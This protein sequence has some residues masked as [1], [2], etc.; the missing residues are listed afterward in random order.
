MTFIA[1]AVCP[2]GQAGSI[3]SN[4]LASIGLRASRTLEPSNTVSLLS[5]GAIQTDRPRLTRADLPHSIFSVGDIRID[6]RSEIAAHFALSPVQAD[7]MHDLDLFTAAW[8]KWGFRALDHLVGGFAVAMWDEGQRTLIL[9]RDHVGERPIYFIHHGDLLAFASLPTAL[10]VV[11]GVDTSL[12]ETYMMEHLA[13]LTGARSASFFRNIRRLPPGHF[14]VFKNGELKLCRYWHPL[15][16]PPTRLSRDEEYAEALVEIF[17]R[18][19]QA[20]LRT[21][22]GVGSHLS[23]GMDSGAVTATAALHLG[24]QQLTAFTAVPQQRFGNEAPFGRFG[25]EGP[26]AARLAAMYPNIQ[27]KLIDAS[28]GDMLVEVESMGKRLGEPVYNPLNLM[29][30]KAITSEA[31]LLGLTVL[32]SGSCGNVTLSNGGLIGLSESLRKGNW[33]QLMKLVYQLRNRGYT[34]YRLAASFVLTPIAPAWL[35]R[36]LNAD[37]KNF[38]MDFSPLRRELISRHDLHARTNAEMFSNLQSVDAYRARTFEYYDAG[39]HNAVSSLYSQV[40]LRDPTQDKRMFEFCFS[41]PVEQYLAGGQTRSLVRRAMRGRLPEATLQCRD[42]G[43]QSADWFLVM[44]ARLQQMKA[45]L[46]LIRTSPM[47][48]RLLDLDRLG[49]LLENWPTQGFE[50][51]EIADSW[52]YALSRGIAAGQFIRQFE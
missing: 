52:H 23:G 37:M 20:R 9:I 39:T 21:T 22:G 27:H 15:D 48:N 25:D 41:I 14:L 34:G 16:A 42:R 33:L 6:N 24:T 8:E 35:R 31:R 3:S 4:V 43:L 40:D 12:D 38:K 11:P 17:D 2:D 13:L 30:S 50:R 47:A 7:S 5:S 1:G 51:A 28:H 26:A 44:G 49:N 18:A 32:L 19:V 36:Q 10:R 46:A 29:W 45:E